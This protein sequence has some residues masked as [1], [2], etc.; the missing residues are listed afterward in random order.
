WPLEHTF[1]KR[2]VATFSTS[3][4]GCFTSEHVDFLRD[5]LPA[6]TLVSEIRLKNIMALTLLQTYVGP[7][8]S[9]QIMIAAPTV[10]PLPRVVTP[11]RICSL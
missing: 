2:H 3:R 11:D 7:H 6:L 10:A 1:C 8:A 5:L 9:E 4:P